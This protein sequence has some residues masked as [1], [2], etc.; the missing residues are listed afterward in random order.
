MKVYVKNAAPGY[1]Y[2]E[3]ME[4]ILEYLNAHGEL[5]VS[6]KTVERLYREF[7]DEIYCAG[8]I[9][10]NAYRLEEFADWLEK[11]DL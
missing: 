1:D 2:P 6:G 4:K 3:E 9:C 11:I 8:W 5:R 10:V 7:S